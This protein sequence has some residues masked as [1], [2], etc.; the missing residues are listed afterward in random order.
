MM[1][2]SGS[3]YVDMRVGFGGVAGC[4]VFGAP[5]DVW[6]SIVERVLNVKKVLR[7]VD[8]NLLFKRPDDQ[9]SLS[10][11]EELSVTMGVKTNPAKNHDFAW[12]Q[13]YI[14]FVWNG[15]NHTVRL[16]ADKLSKRL[17]HVKDL[18][19]TD[20]R[21]AHKDV[22]KIV[23]RLSHTCHVVPH[24]R[25]YMNALYRWTT[26]WMNKSAIQTTPQDVRED[27][28]EWEYCLSN[29]KDRF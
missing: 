27:L 8:N 3:I 20:S 25:S 15:Q 14:G 19:K 26:S 1:D 9:I 24:M 7:W 4:G 17:Q 5:A 10:T 18:L 22:E 12:E 2:F 16:P 13:K 23:G 21:W 6:K 29:F 11:V 28:Q